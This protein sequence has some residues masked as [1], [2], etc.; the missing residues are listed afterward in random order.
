MGL[1]LKIH[2]RILMVYILLTAIMFC[3][4]ARVFAINK[5][6]YQSVWRSQNSYKV[7]IGTARGTIFDCNLTRITN[8]DKKTVAIISPTPRAITAISGVLEG[9]ELNSVLEKLKKGEPCA[10]RVDKK[11][12]CDGIICKEVYEYNSSRVTAPQL[13][14]YLDTEGHGVCGIEEAFDD[15]LFSDNDICAYFA[16]DASKKLLEGIEPEFDESSLVQNSGIA[17]TINNNIQKI[18][19]DAMEEVNCGAA[20]VMEIGSG[21]IRA[22]V[23]KPTYDVSKVAEYLESP[24]SPFMNR[25]ISLYNVGSAF[26]P[27]VAAA[28]LEDKRYI[29][30]ST[31]CFGSTYIDEHR[32]R[33]HSYLGHGSVDLQLALKESCNI[34]F[35]TV[36]QLLGANAINKMA[37]SLSFGSSIDLGGITA[38]TGS[39]PSVERLEASS[40]AL[41]NLSIGQGELLL[42]PV[43]ILTLYEAIANGGVYHLPSIIEGSVKD[44]V[45]INKEQN[46]PTRAMSEQTANTLKNYLYEVVE[47]GTGKEAKP[48]FCF[49]A[50]K[51][52]TAETGWKKEGKTIQNSW[53]CGFFPFENPKYAVCVMIEDYEQGGVTGAPVFRKIADNITLAGL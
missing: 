9:D 28:I 8:A 41:A 42:S 37:S 6:D 27:C 48:Q 33:C 36:S 23:S 10:V 50:G 51:T 32:F 1:K 14:G 11:I 24:N 20:V 18:T 25:A 7:K 4:I 21:K 19:V 5:T 12:V 52:A 26:K 46:S 39:L 31:N 2:W 17:L 38:E 13:I 44:G 40:T 43:A 30:Y 16:V 47:N 35:Y 34:F 22:M 3:C 29:N 53:F 45:L 15:T 49:A